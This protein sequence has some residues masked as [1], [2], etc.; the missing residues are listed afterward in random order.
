MSMD[1]HFWLIWGIRKDLIPDH[2]NPDS[3]GLSL[4]DSAHDSVPSLDKYVGMEIGHELALQGFEQNE[5]TIGFEELEKARKDVCVKLENLGIYH[6]PELY[7]VQ[8]FG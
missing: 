6:E 1:L 2:I 5:S 7:I 4:F 8:T 3:A